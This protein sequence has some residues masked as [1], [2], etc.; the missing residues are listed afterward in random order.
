M[1]TFAKVS[2]RDTYSDYSLPNVIFGYKEAQANGDRFYIAAQFVRGKLP[3]EVILGNGKF[4]DGY[5][6]TPL[7]PETHYT[8]YLRAVTEHNGVNK[9]E[10]SE[11][12]Q[13]IHKISKRL[14]V[15]RILRVTYMNISLVR[16]CPTG[17]QAF[18]ELYH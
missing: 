16:F 12:Y 10:N 11:L 13:S 8:V 17:F 9:P 7:Q 18:L 14:L 5:Q 3:D 1:F 6:N 15:I 2:K 4:Y